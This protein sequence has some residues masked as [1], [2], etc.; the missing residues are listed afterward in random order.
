MSVHVGFED[1]SSVKD[2]GEISLLFEGDVQREASNQE[3][4]TCLGA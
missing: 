3:D 1:G 2:D 4:R